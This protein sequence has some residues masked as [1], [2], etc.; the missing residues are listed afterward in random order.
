MSK[1]TNSSQKFSAAFKR[2]VVLESVAPGANIAAL[3]R[4]HGISSSRIYAWRKDERF[5][6]DVIKD[7]GF[8]LVD[9]ADDGS[10]GVAG[11]SE[12][13]PCRGGQIEITLENGRRLSIWHNGDVGF[14]L[15][16]ARGLAA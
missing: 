1:G 16:L 9:I 8:T 4:K 3:C 13:A 11:G 15:E 10:E 2:Q 14:V 12:V 7:L 5:Q 6:T